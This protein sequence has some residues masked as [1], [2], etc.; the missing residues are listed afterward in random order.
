[1][2]DQRTER[3]PQMIVSRPRKDGKIPVSYLFFNSGRRIN[4]IRTKPIIAIISIALLT[5]F[6]YSLY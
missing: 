4:K 5:W 3:K 1:M 6:S 2:N